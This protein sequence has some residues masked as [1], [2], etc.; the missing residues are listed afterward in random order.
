MKCLIA[1]S[2]IAILASSVIAADSECRVF[3]CGSITQPGEGTTICIK[4]DEPKKA[5]SIQS[6]EGTTPYCQTDAAEWN[7]PGTAPEST[8]CGANITPYTWPPTPTMEDGGALPGDY[9]KTA[10]DCFQSTEVA[11]T[12][13]TCVAKL[14]LGE[15][16]TASNQCPQGHYCT[17]DKSAAAERV[18][19]PAIAANAACDTV[20]ICQFGLLCATKDGADV[21]MC[22]GN[23]SFKNGEKYTMIVPAQLSMF[24]S[25]EENADDVDPTIQVASVCETHFAMTVDAV[26]MKYEC[27]MGARNEEQKRKSP[28]LE[29]LCKYNKFDNADNINATASTTPSMCGFNKDNAAYCPMLKGD[30]DVVDAI[31]AAYKKASPDSSKCHP[32]SGM[33]TGSLCNEI[34]ENVWNTTEFFTVTQRLS[35]AATLS[36]YNVANNDECVASSITRSFW[37]GRFGDDA[38]NYSFIGTLSVF[39]ILMAFIF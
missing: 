27:R 15:V 3:S 4:A 20:N 29:T 12:A 2:L 38:M 26:N 7:T 33:R 11:C 32:L 19:T 23:N 10:A 22:Y 25:N 21:S 24:Q 6:C 36:S 37:F 35:Q 30:D 28:T 34:K 31:E 14:G 1:I 5:F 9:C 18:C 16:C 8:S 39:A 13:G 17:T